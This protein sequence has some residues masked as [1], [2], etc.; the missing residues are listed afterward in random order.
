MKKVTRHGWQ[1]AALEVKWVFNGFFVDFV[2]FIALF[3]YSARSWGPGDSLEEWY[4]LC[5]CLLLLR[6][7]SWILPPSLSL[8]DGIPFWLR[9]GWCGAKQEMMRSYIDPS[10]ARVSYFIYVC[11]YYSS[12]TMG[13]IYYHKLEISQ[14]IYRDN[15]WNDSQA[16][17]I[18]SARFDP[19]GSSGLLTDS[20]SIF[21]ILIHCYGCRIQINMS[22]SYKEWEEQ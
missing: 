16:E 6:S 17:S 12:F 1:I 9:D 3:K 5:S 7:N 22:S 13:G 20:A 21:S 11:I 14:E 15:L 18:I 8:E 2:A 19:G 4:F 10:D